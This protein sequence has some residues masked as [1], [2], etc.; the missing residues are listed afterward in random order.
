MSTRRL[1]TLRFYWQAAIQ[2][3]LRPSVVILALMALGA[4]MDVATVG[5][6]V[7]LLDA[8]TDPVR[9]AHNP[10]VAGLGRLLQRP[11]AEAS[12]GRVVFVLLVA[13]CSLF[14]AR[15]AV[16]LWSQYR[17]VSI[18]VGLRRKM[19]VAL[20]ERFLHG[21]YE[22]VSSRGRGTVLNDINSPAEALC[23]S[24]MNLGYFVTGL[25][26]SVLLIGLL[27]VLSWW[28]TL[29]I[30]LLAIGGIR[31]WRRYAD[32][33][34][35]AQGRILYDLRADQSKLQVDAIDGL[36][37]VK[38]QQLESR[39]VERH[40]GLSAGELAPELRFMVLRDSPQLVHEVIA[41][42]IVLGLG[43]VTFLV[44]SMG[45]RVSMLAAFLLAIRK[46]A[47]AVSTMAMAMANLNRD[48][49]HLEVI[50]QVL[51]ELPQEERGGASVPS[52][53]QIELR[54]VEF[55]YPSRPERPVLREV[56]LTLRKGTVTAIVGPTGSG[57]TT[58]AN[59]LLRLYEPTSGR[60][61]VDGRP[62]ESLELSGWRRQV[63]YVP[64]DVFIFNASI[65]DN[66][67]L[68]DESIAMPTIEEA[69][70]LAELQPVVSA[71][72][73]GYETPVGDRGFRL[74]GGQC[75]RL[76]IA[77][78]V[79]RRPQVLIFDEATSALDN[80]TE[81]AVYEAIRALR[82]EAIVLV[83]AH[84]LSTIRDADQIVVLHEGRLTESG[85]HE[86]LLARDELYA[87]LY[88]ENGR[89]GSE[90]LEEVPR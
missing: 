77:R 42:V 51:R 5:L 9:A 68:W 13:A 35:A 46:I 34:T 37:V 59:L 43:A 70:R 26:N 40:D 65:R 76:S 44:P 61:L 36:K 69:A 66:I 49:R 21:R 71:L 12:G 52:M 79:A 86:S 19:K 45:I 39:I 89:A 58:I 87:R 1:G 48:R 56:S 33:R 55:V 20:L 30:G 90:A 85:T 18:A 10:V 67:A 64:Q 88:R 29:I 75:Q 78:A 16:Q 15:S 62:L 31:A 50:E 38:A 73:K 6:S 32:S 4:V 80:V 72:P 57:K 63:G 47:P 11:G 83:I 41:A 14:V 74:S 28:C 82:R 25:C 24:M 17:T 8:L 84:R 81:R 7:P 22:T 53:Q 60:I 3:N 27:L 23:G 54:D 2:P